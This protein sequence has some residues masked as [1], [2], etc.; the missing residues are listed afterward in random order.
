MAYYL[1]GLLP[2]F[3]M[4]IRNPTPFSWRII[5]SQKKNDHYS[6]HPTFPLLS[7]INS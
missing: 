6:V 1:H 2:A 7:T 5:L 4:H 3:I